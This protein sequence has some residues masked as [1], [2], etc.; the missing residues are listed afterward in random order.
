[1]FPGDPERLAEPAGSGAE[2]TIVV[3]AA[4]LPHPLESVGGLECAD[5]DRTRG[6]DLLAHEVQ[7]PVDAVRPV[8]VGMPRRAE[9]RGVALGPATVPVRGRILVVVG[10]DLD[11]RASDAVDEERDTD[12]LRRDVVN[13]A[14]EEVPGEPHSSCGRRA[15]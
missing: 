1:V 8:D 2:Q 3:Q 14:R 12:E 13:R 4:S 11:D 15:S 10:L 5:Q 6:V 7:T 9:H